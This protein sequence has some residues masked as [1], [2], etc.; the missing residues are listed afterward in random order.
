MD[1]CDLETACRVGHRGR[2][3]HPIVFD[4]INPLMGTLKPQAD[5]QQYVDWYTGRWWAGCYIWYSEQGSELAVALSSLYR[6]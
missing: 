1:E 4:A 2:A 3:A 5:R 6:M